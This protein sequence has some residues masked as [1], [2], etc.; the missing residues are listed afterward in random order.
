MAAPDDARHRL[1]ERYQGT[2]CE[3]RQGAGW[4]P[5]RICSDRDVFLISAWNP[6]SR[7]LTQRENLRAD[8]A[9]GRA[10]RTMGLMPLRVR[11]VAPDGTAEEGWAIP[12]EVR[13]SLDLLRRFA[14][15]A[16]LVLGPRG[17]AVLWSSGDQEALAAP[18]AGMLA[19]IDA[20]SRRR[21]S[22][23]AA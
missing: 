13:R 19:P 16:G 9:L 10:L 17:R 1:L 8:A 22:S 18:S 4:T 14:Q 21:R 3:V 2:R 7:P 20:S 6:G 23:G 15:D 5:W 11:G 12:H